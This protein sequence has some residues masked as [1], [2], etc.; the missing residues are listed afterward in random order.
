M[1][2]KW[3]QNSL[4]NDFRDSIWSYVAIN[5][6]AYCIPWFKKKK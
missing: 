4:E 5:T 6:E 2:D 1:K 3:S